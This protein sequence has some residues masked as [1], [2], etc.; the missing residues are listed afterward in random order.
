MACLLAKS[1]AIL[2]NSAYVKEV[3]ESVVGAFYN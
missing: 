3:C 1:P 2:D